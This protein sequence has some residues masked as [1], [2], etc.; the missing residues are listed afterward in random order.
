MRLKFGQKIKTLIGNKISNC[1][2]NLKSL[3]GSALLID[4]LKHFN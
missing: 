3:H 2:K 4:L 1:N